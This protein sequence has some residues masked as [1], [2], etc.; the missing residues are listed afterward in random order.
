VIRIVTNFFWCVVGFLQTYNGAVTAVA[1][2]AI[3][4]FTFFLVRVSNRQARLTRDAVNVAKRSADAA[5]AI[6]LPFIRADAPDELTKVEN[7][8]DDTGGLI[9]DVETP[10]LP[11]FSRI[12]NL[13]FR[14]IGRTTAAPIKLEL[15]WKVALS[16]GPEEPVYTWSRRCDHGTVLPGDNQPYQL[17]CSKFCVVLAAEDQH[18]IYANTAALWVFGALTYRDFLNESHVSRF[19]WRWGCPD[20]VGLYYFYTDEH[21]P[22]QY[23]AK[24]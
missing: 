6:E 10:D 3:S 20:G 19:C 1:T 11:E 22:A 14:N 8:E 15:G 16:L 5:I 9:W 17:D 23:T 4:V 7:I 24:S 21:T 18:V 12:Y 2:I 13:T